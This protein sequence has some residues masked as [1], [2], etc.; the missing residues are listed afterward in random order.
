LFGKD[1]LPEDLAEQSENSGP[2]FLGQAKPAA[3]TVEKWRS[4]K[5]GRVFKPRKEPV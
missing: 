2:V 5:F 3:L 4:P 1:C